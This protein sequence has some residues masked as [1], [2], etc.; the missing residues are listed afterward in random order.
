VQAFLEAACAGDLDSLKSYSPRRSTCL[1]AE[2]VAA[3]DEEDK[4][5][6]AVRDANS[7]QRSTSPRARAAP[8]YAPSSSI[9]EL[10]LPVDPEDDDGTYASPLFFFTNHSFNLS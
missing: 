10:G 7:A 4:G 5:A 2:L 1:P 9:D 6:A 8:T 3:L